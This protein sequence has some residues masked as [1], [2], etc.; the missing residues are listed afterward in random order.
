[1]EGVATYIAISCA[2]PLFK[3]W[4][5]V[6][7]DMHKKDTPEL[8]EAMGL[9]AGMVL[10]AV[11]PKDSTLLLTLIGLWIGALDD[12]LDM[13]WRYKI[14]LSA[15]SYILLMA[16][17]NTSVHIFG[18]LID[19][20][21]GYHLYMILWCIWCGNA[22]NIHAGI[23]GI[24]VGQTLVIAIGLL[25]F[26]NDTNALTSYI[27]VA[28]ALLFYNWYPANVFVG[29]SWCY[30]SGMFF[31]AVARHE[32]EQ[33]ALIMWPQILNTILSIPELTGLRDCPRHRM[34]KYDPES[35]TLYNSGS[36]T[37]MNAI[38]WIIGPTHEQYLC[39][40]LLGLQVSGIAL[41]FVV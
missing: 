25:F 30:L 21:I 19:L 22:I 27:F 33:L 5:I 26:S 13:R 34:P 4:G 10:A 24:E 2:K 20:G 8:P 40:L 35:D 18:I 11:L 37:L 3:R 29:D 41:A 9:I 12:I 23:N 32:T 31:V 36:G 38:L 6:G 39:Q 14:L 7:R 1:M 16:E 17:N 28:C 15:G